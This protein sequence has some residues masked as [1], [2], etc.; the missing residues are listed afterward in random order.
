[1]KPIDIT[2]QKFGK[3]T[4]IKL[5]HIKKEKHGTRHFWLFKCEC[6][7]EC[8]I[9]KQYAISGHTKSCGCSKSEM[10]TNALLTHNLS[11]SRI[12]ITYHSMIARCYKETVQA[13]KN[14]GKRGIKVYDEWKND[15]MAF[16]N[17]AMANGYKDDL[18]L[19]RINV[20]GNYEPDNCRWITKGEQT[21]NTRHNRNVTFRGKTHC[22]SE[23]AEIYKID[24]RLLGQRLNAGWSFTRAVK[25]PA[26]EYK[27]RS[28][29]LIE[30][31]GELHTLKEWTEILQIHSTTFYRK[32]KLYRQG[33]R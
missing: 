18:T 14:Y 23:W 7:K 13:Y 33:S 5:D 4:A 16:Y 24:K 30:Y 10:I 6:G 17:W 20:N 15:F 28:E 1:M 31:Q 2:G 27:Q 9:N 3:L 29:K 8:I 25:T 32:L 22:V 19:D 26:S 12:Y 11:K 21:R